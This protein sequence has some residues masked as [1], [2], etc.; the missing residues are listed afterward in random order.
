MVKIYK[1]NC[2]S[3]H[4]INNGPFNNGLNITT[5]EAILSLANIVV[6]GD[7]ESS[8]LYQRITGIGGYMPPSWAPNGNEILSSDE[9]NTVVAWINGLNDG[10]TDPLA[11]N[12]DESATDDNDSCEYDCN[13]SLNSSVTGD[14]CN[15]SNIDIL[16]SVEGGT[17]DYNY[18]WSD[19]ST[20]FIN[21]NL[22]TGFYSVEI[23]DNN[24]GCV[25]NEEFNLL[26][27][28]IQVTASIQYS[29]GSCSSVTV[30]VVGAT[31]ALPVLFTVILA[32]IMFAAL[33]VGA[34][35]KLELLK[36]TFSIP[37]IV[38]GAVEAPPA[39][40]VTVKV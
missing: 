22:S 10:C 13:L 25:I 30:D 15:G 18:L 20:D 31:R 21:L 4:G 27:E 19:G 6:P 36:I 23:T 2:A 24:T 5:E 14:L 38:A 8:I 16:L 11:C 17:D 32:P 34:V 1:N 37:V 40:I 7:Y 33:I 35:D 39:A 3:C 12:Y 29:L 9:V 26:A 28:D